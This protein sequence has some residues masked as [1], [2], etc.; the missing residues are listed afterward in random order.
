LVH[1]T[2]ECRRT[3]SAVL[4]KVHSV[5]LTG[6]DA[7]NGEIETDVDTRGI[8]DGRARPDRARKK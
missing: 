1:D 3:L 6:I 5:I 4:A 8:L 7:A 2:L